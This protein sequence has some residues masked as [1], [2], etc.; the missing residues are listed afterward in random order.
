MKFE[1]FHRINREEGLSD[2]DSAGIWNQNPHTLFGELEITEAQV[3][4]TTRVFIQSRERI[5]FIVRHLQTCDTCVW[6][7]MEQKRTATC[8]EGDRFYA[9]VE[10]EVNKYRAKKGED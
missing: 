2:E 4:H 10:E 6:D 7:W 8:P 1:E 5:G 9:I 3:R